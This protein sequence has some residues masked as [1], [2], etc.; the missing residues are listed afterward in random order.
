MAGQFGEVIGVEAAQAEKVRRTGRRV[1]GPINLK[2]AL[3]GK[4]QRRARPLF[5]A[6]GELFAHGDIFGAGLG[7]G[8]G[9]GLGR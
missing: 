8:F 9:L 6:P 7:F 4:R 2:G 5:S 1:L 3:A